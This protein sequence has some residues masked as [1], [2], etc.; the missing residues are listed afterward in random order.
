MFKLIIVSEIN[1]YLC[2]FIVRTLLNSRYHW[3]EHEE[4]GGYEGWVLLNLVVRITL[5]APMCKMCL[6]SNFN[7]MVLQ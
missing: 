3:E 5:F 6:D 1:M 2:S 4:L 7:L